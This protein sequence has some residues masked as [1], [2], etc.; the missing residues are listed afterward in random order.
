MN[1]LERIKD[2]ENNDLK[3]IKEILSKGLR[4]IKE[5]ASNEWLGV[6][7]VSIC[8]LALELLERVFG[9]E[10][11]FP[12]DIEALVKELEIDVIYQP[13]NP[14]LKEGEKCVH[15]MVGTSFIRP[16]GPNKKPIACIWIDSESRQ[17]E[18]RYA[19]AH[20]LAHCLI[21]GEGVYNSAYYLMP[22]LFKDMEEMVADIFAIF[23]LIPIQAFFEIFYEYIEVQ[24]EPVRTSEW[25]KYLSFVANVSYEEVSIGYQN[26][27][28]VSGIIYKLRHNEIDL[29]KQ[30]GELVAA[31]VKEIIMRQFGELVKSMS[32]DME[33]FLYL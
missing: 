16:G 31:D 3:G 30:I 26:I 13:L 1:G 12:V 18:R 15:K 28:Y 22:M 27:R 17:E 10:Y 21:N 32:D 9:K 14:I 24:N 8:A 25:L 23:L 4:E 7:Y 11:G 33:E 20:E 19:L 6:D 2:I 29:E 5:I